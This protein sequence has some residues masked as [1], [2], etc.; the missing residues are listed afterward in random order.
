MQY[1][2][3]FIELKTKQNARIP[4]GRYTR[5]WT[6]PPKKEREREEEEAAANAN[7]QTRGQWLPRVGRAVA[8]Q[9]IGNFQGVVMA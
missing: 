8:G 9:H 6:T 7:T 1:D 5:I 4:I 2:T 3:T